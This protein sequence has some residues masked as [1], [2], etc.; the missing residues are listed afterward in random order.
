MVMPVA[1][2]INR[3]WSTCRTGLGSDRGV[4]SPGWSNPLQMLRLIVRKRASLEKSGGS[5]E[6]NIKS[7]GQID[8]YER[9]HPQGI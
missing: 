9:L 1:Y 4:G 3:R 8:L 5:G 2:L 6:K 7:K